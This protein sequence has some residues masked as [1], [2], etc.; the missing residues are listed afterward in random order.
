[1]RGEGHATLEPV[2]SIA[3]MSSPLAATD[4]DQQCLLQP[5]RD[6]ALE[7]DLKRIGRGSPSAA[8]Y[9]MSCPW[10]ARAIQRLNW[11]HGLLV[12][13]DFDLSDLMV[14]VVSQENGCRFCYAATR[15]QLRMMG[16][17]EERVQELE[18]QLSSGG[19]DRSSVAA[20][21]YARRL[22]R[23]NPPPDRGEVAALD[24][25]GFTPAQIRELSFVIA[26]IC[27]FN[28]LATLPALPPEPMERMPD[29]WFMALVRP[30]MARLM[31]GWRWRGLPAVT[32]AAT[33]LPC[34]AMRAQFEGSPIA[35][36]LA[37]A[38]RDL[39]GPTAL[40]RRAKA[41]MLAVIAR[42][43]G[44]QALAADVCRMLEQEGLGAEDIESVVTHLDAPGLDDAERA[45]VTFSRET[46]WY[47]PRSIQRR[48]RAL[49]ECL[50]EPAL[51]EAIGLAAFANLLC[52]L[53]LALVELA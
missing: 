20:V 32:A 9:F 12:E 15:M 53:D 21:R 37:E 31:R 19:L 38:L 27:F 39:L 1:M 48:A 14:L 30:V 3:T 40:T 18:R 33:D 50:R 8:A 13:L 28:R 6:A 43:L 51:V 29:R 10:L 36:A 46:I 45:L 44:S 5:T 49:R 47:E 4:W 7:K 42:G 23:S 34:V 16:M 35:D 24:A 2:S 22:S 17:D 11:D 26:G 52:R 41:L 25:A